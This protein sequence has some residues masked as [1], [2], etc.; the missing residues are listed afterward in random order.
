MK[1][2]INWRKWISVTMVA[3]TVVAAVKISPST[4]VSYAF[5]QTTGTIKGTSV[6]IRQ[7]ATTSSTSV[8]KLSA[9]AAV[10]VID[11]T[12]QG[13]WNWYQISF[14]Y[15]GG[16]TTGWVRADL[17]TVNNAAAPTP[18]N[19]ASGDDAA[20]TSSLQAAGFPASYCS[21]LLA[22][23][24]QYPNWQFQ[25]VQ[26]GLD[27]NTVIENE[28]KLG[29]NLV[30]A[31]SNDACKSTQSGAYDWASNKWY[32]L[33]GAGWVNASSEMIAYCM[34]PRNYLDATNIFQ[35]ATNEYEPYQNA[36]GVAALLNGS[37]MAGNYT[38]SDGAVRSYPDTFT[39]VGANLG[40]SPYHLAS[41]CRQEQ[42]T[43]G[44]SGS[45]SGTVSGYNNLY[46]YFNVGAYAKN[47]KSAVENG[48]IYARNQ[49]WNTR[50]A[51]IQG[52]A[53][54]VANRYVKI[55]QNTVYFEKFNV[56]TT[57]LNKY[58]HQYMTNVEAATSEGKSMSKAYTDLGQGLIFRIP[59]YA[60]MPDSVCTR[61]SS[62]NPNNWLSSLTVAGYNITPSFQGGTTTYS[63]IVGESVSSVAISANPVAATSS[64]SGTGTVSLNYGNNAISVV[65][66]AQN[67]TQRAYNLNIVRQ[68]SGTTSGGGTTSY[69]K[70][71]VNGDGKISL[72]D[73]VHI[74]R[75]LLGISTLE[76][77]QFAA[78]DINGDGKVT[79][80]DYAMVKRHLLGIQLIQ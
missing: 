17:I 69:G 38:D 29:V 14:P 56:V 23:H 27:W 13:G 43:K 50:Y 21:Y 3:V 5:T 75:H 25:A 24:K 20:Y 39:T 48:L 34:D 46:N 58:S 9:P 49:G 26:T 42:G 15:N 12:S 44:T 55:G 6:N 40:V 8:A 57:S 62:G 66:T 72:I 59:V 28:S 51:S 78:A 45:I 53:A 41:R 64:V 33:D 18:D 70:G 30:Q 63:M 74:K 68:G 52:G 76:G 47:G 19:G 1:F 7:S 60:N 2:K 71:D 61:P 65:C 77:T 35:F 36:A 16:T 4:S 80:L 32:G 67:G 31:S 11:Q 37:F 22:L 73:L 10:T 54:T 79:L